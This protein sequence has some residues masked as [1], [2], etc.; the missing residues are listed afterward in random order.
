MVREEKRLSAGL[1]VLTQACF[2]TLAIVSQECGRGNGFVFAYA[3]LIT[4][5]DACKWPP[6]TTEHY[7]AVDLGK[8]QVRKNGPAE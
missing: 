2:R 5:L 3:C 8:P 1:D 6:P 7:L 4:P